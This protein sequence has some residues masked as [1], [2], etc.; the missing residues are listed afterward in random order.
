MATIMTSPPFHNR[1]KSGAS[2]ATNAGGEHQNL[3]CKD[4]CL[5]ANIQADKGYAISLVPE[6]L[7]AGYVGA[8]LQDNR[9]GSG[10]SFVRASAAAAINISNDLR[11]M[12]GIEHRE[13]MAGTTDTT[14]KLKLTT[15]YQLRQDAD[16]RFSYHK[17]TAEEISL[18]LGFY[19]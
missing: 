12:L 8:G 4:D 15:R 11:S 7:L 3:A 14:N 9:N 10:N 5:I 17:D 16:L 2:L 1:P 18:A 19:W 13:Y 6:L